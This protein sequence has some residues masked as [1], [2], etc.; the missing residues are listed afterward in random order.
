M[1]GLSKKKPT[2]ED[3]FNTLRSCPYENIRSLLLQEWWRTATVMS[4]H[5]YCCQGQVDIPW[6]EK[7]NS[8]LKKHGWTHERFFSKYVTDEE[9]YRP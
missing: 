3:T 5:F 2:A 4:F 6:V 1:G 8:I 9:I 7:R